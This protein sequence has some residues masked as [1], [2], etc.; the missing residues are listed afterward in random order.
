MLQEGRDDGQSYQGKQRLAPQYKVPGAE[1]QESSREILLSDVGAGMAAQGL[2]QEIGY[3]KAG[4]EACSNLSYR[5]GGPLLRNKVAA[6]V[7]LELEKPSSIG[8]PCSECGA[9]DSGV[10]LKAPIDIPLIITT[11]RSSR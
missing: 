11:A 6:Q 2:V 8:A 3:A 9:S 7:R 1:K 4:S 5:T 10:V